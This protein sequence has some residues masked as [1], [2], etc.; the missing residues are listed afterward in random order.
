MASTLPQPKCTYA[1]PAWFPKDGQHIF[2]LFN[3]ADRH[4]A[5][6]HRAVCLAHLK[7]EKV[8]RHCLALVMGSNGRK[9]K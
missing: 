3:V 8:C 7:H 6:L 9:K 4:L 5:H 2:P 1:L